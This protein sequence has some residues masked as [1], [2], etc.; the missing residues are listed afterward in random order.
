MEIIDNINRLLGDDLKHSILPGA[1]LR[2]A[3]SCFSIYA[4]EALNSRIGPAPGS[5]HYQDEDLLVRASVAP[6]ERLSTHPALRAQLQ[7]G[8][9]GHSLRLGW[10]PSFTGRAAPTATEP[11]THHASGSLCTRSSPAHTEYRKGR[12][13]A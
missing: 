8:W 3:A 10:R 1:K 4:Y 13:L 6:D 2:I 9:L 5:W 11:V 7:G 12:G